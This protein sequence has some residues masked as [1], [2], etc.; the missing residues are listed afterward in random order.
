MKRDA[1][2]TYNYRDRRKGDKYTRVQR[3]RDLVNIVCKSNADF[4]FPALRAD[5]CKEKKERKNLRPAFIK[6]KV[7]I[8]T[9]RDTNEDLWGHGWTV[10]T[11]IYRP[12]VS[13]SRKPFNGRHYRYCIAFEPR[14]GTPIQQ[15]CNF[16]DDPRNK[17]RGERR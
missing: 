7:F 13:L 1:H 17:R 6:L 5:R 2:D 3:S 16:A 14:S 8:R 12:H 4:H 10:D 15:G 9:I 11:W